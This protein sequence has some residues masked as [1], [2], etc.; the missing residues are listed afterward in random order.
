MRVKVERF[1]I[2]TVFGNVD[3]GRVLTVSESQGKMLIDNGLA[4]RI[5]EAGPASVQP[6]AGAT[7][8]SRPAPA[9]GSS[10][11]AAPALPLKTASKSKNGG[12]KKKAGK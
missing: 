5:V 10:S 6:K 12:Q 1:F 3:P 11:P 9:N 7:N 2:S 4:S 8:F